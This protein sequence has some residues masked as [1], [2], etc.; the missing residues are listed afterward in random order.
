MNT[1]F[2]SRNPTPDPSV[3]TAFLSIFAYL[4]AAASFA[5]AQ[6]SPEIL[7][8][9]RVTF[10]IRAPM[11]SKVVVTG[12]FTKGLELEKTEAELW[13]GTTVESVPPGIHEYSFRVDGIRM[14]DPRNGQIRPK[15]WPYASMLHIPADPP[16]YWDIR[17]I[18]HGILHLRDYYST[19]LK[20]WRK[21]IV[22]TP[23]NTET[24]DRPLPVL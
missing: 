17:D 4:F 13:E 10:R 12:H 19:T 8:D 16:A 9:G 23:P 14:I 6:V 21:L 18:P 20:S 1:V 5:M 3:K 11:A 22:Y 2:H 24:M 7:P 15:R